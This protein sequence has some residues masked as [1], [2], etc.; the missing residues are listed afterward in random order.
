MGAKGAG[1][2]VDGVADVVVEACIGVPRAVEEIIPMGVN[3][4]AA[5]AHRPGGSG[6]KRESVGTVE[7][8]DKGEVTEKILANFP[9][10][11]K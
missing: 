10:G 2:K 9:A 7:G 11:G 5:K 6:K 1:D 3:F 8:Q 4:L